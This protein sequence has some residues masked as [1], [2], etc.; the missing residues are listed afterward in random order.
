MCLYVTVCQQ[1]EL[2][3]GDLRRVWGSHQRG[4]CT[5]V[6]ECWWFHSRVVHLSYLKDTSIFGCSIYPWWTVH[7]TLYTGLHTSIHTSIYCSFSQKGRICC[8]H[9]ILLPHL[10]SPLLSTISMWNSFEDDKLLFLD[11][12]SERL[13]LSHSFLRSSQTSHHIH[14]CRDVQAA[15]SHSSGCRQCGWLSN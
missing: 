11:L 3:Q 15:L 14:A 6:A 7:A 2:R 10:Y 13:F 9:I 5:S 1:R 8:Q 12:P 4:I